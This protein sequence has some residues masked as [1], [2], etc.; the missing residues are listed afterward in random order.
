MDTHTGSTVNRLCLKKKYRVS[1]MAK[2]RELRLIHPNWPYDRS[3]TL[4]MPP[5]PSPYTQS[6]RE[7]SS[8]VL[9]AKVEESPAPLEF[10]RYRYNQ[11]N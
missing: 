7:S 4:S 9:H 5:P 2:V 8:K 6:N 3:A 10:D 1:G 11:Y